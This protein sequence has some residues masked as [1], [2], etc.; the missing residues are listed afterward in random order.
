[1]SQTLPI[2][3]PST[4]RNLIE[5]QRVVAENCFDDP[6]GLTA[7]S[8]CHNFLGDLDRI[9]AL[10]HGR[11]EAVCFTLAVQ[12]YQYSLS[13][14]VLGHYRHAFGSLRLSFELFLSCIYFSA[15]EVKLRQWLAGNRDIF[16]SALIDND[17]GVFSNNFVGAFNTEFA[18][19]SRQFSGLATTVY[20]ECSEFVHGNPRTHESLSG[21]ISFR[22]PVLITWSEHLESL[23]LC[24]FFCFLYRYSSSMGR[25]MKASLEPLMTETFGHE[26]AVQSL[27][28]EL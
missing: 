28:Q 8:K 19:L 11:P 16:W 18:G 10:T 22:K 24:V 21:N 27:F 14:L 1:M 9:S 23:R 2:D 7:F 17:K 6:D 25:D 3:I 15:H 13:A 4:Y 26:A 5:A 12:E 20:R